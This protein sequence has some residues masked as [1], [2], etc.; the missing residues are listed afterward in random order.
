[1]NNVSVL[2]DETTN[3]S[4]IQE[5]DQKEMSH[6]FPTHT[7]TGL[8]ATRWNGQLGFF[9]TPQWYESGAPTTK[10]GH[11]Y[12]HT[13]SVTHGTYQNLETMPDKHGQ[14]R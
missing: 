5:D 9:Y 4:H 14:S 7:G 13:H 10:R 1:M 8:S 2:N 6:D 12:I 3:D 11:L